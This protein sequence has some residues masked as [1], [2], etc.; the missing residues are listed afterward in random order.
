MLWAP[1]VIHAISGKRH[2]SSLPLQNRGWALDLLRVI[3][4]RLLQHP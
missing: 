3:I 1:G 2:L 4:T